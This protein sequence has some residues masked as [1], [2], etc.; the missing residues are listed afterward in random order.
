M[1]YWELPVGGRDVVLGASGSPCIPTNVFF[2]L[3]SRSLTYKSTGHLK[4]CTEQYK[5]NLPKTVKMT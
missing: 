3:V 4:E 2:F 1:L 5:N